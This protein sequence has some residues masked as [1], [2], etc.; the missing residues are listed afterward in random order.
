MIRALGMIST[1]YRL[2]RSERLAE[3]RPISATPFGGRYRLLDFSMSN[4]VNA[5]I[6]TV[7]VVLPY[8]MRPLLDHISAGKSW[9]LDRHSGGLYML[10]AVTPALKARVQK[11]C[12][13]DYLA[14]IEFLTAD[15]A[16]IVVITDGNHVANVDLASIIATHEK[17]GCQVT[18]VYKKG[19]HTHPLVEAKLVLDETGQVRDIRRTV[20]EDTAGLNNTFADIFIFNRELLVQLLTTTTGLEFKDLLDLVRYNLNKMVVRS[21][22]FTGYMREVF[23]V[24]DYHSAS[25][26]LL[27]PAIK[28]E[29]FD[30][31]NKIITK[32]KDSPPTKYR[33]HAEVSCA[34]I[35]NGCR[36][37]GEV[38]NSII[39]RNVNLK[40]N[41]CIKNSVL[42]QSCIVG[43]N[44]VLENVVLDK[45][46]QVPDNTVLK[47]QG[48]T[49]LYIPKGTKI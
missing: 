19:L 48:E 27:E 10:P 1:N 45:G 17:S 31:P 3:Y 13:K 49:P 42:M 12:A 43:E 26:D 39:F 9:N 22:E 24:S 23:T 32:I 6:R 30:G 38:D 18:L 40:K 37:D 14:N 29:L 35:S 2:N 46:I 34:M 8:N 7:G 11:F 21:Y 4:L 25:M 44:C 20:D 5:G 28:A 41:C 36:V 47:A 16:E 15:D 33:D